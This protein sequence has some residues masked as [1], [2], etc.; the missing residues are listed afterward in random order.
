VT[1]LAALVRLVPIRRGSIAVAGRPVAGLGPERLLR[2]GVALVPQGRRLFPHLTVRRNLLLGGYS[3]RD[4]AAVEQDAADLLARH[5]A[6]PG[7][8]DR[9]AGLLS[10]GQQQL[11][12]LGR[13]LLA[14]PKAL[15]LD[16]PLMGLAGGAAAA[17]LD[18]IAAA[19]EAGIA[20][21]VVEHD[22]AALARLADRTVTLID[23]AVVAA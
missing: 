11:V 8:G 2:L 13:A 3:R 19:A 12:A 10:G 6:L 7:V 14:R 5:L 16:E 17:V 1:L 9:P 23:G 15:L 21:L 4:Q 18:E 22:R 20:L